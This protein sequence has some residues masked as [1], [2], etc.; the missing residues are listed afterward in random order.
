[1]GEN[2][3]FNFVT[4]SRMIVPCPDLEVVGFSEVRNSKFV[5]KNEAF[6]GR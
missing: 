6:S 4:P 3:D 5:E 1:M 2:L